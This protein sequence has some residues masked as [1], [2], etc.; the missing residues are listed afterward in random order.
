[1]SLYAWF[2]RAGPS[3]FG[4]SSTAQEVTEGLDL[5]DRRILITGCN[6]GLGRHTLQVLASRGA[7]MLGTARSLQKAEEATADIPGAQP[8]VCELS[9][10]Q[11]VRSLVR[12]LQQDAPLDGIIANAGIM[13]LPQL[14]QVH[15]YEKQFFVN[16]IGHFLLVTGLIPRL[17]ADGRVVM[18]CSSAHTSAPEQGIEFDNLSGEAGYRPWRAYGQSKLANLLFARELARRLE[19]N[20][21]ANAVHPGVIATGLGRHMGS[22]IDVALALASPL[23][24]KS[25]AQGAATQCW[26]AVHPD[27]ATIRGEYL[28]NCNIEMSSRAGRDEQLATDLWER[29]E[30]IAATLS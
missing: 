8:L 25:V 27:T 7:T 21:V 22:W 18:L 19:G 14:E 6:S 28:V 17:G 24:L 9:E 10:P 12:Q 13:A 30:E 5:S 4:Y 11:S 20:R 23:A 29:S 2:T 26:A 1:M 16:H 15:G 3:G